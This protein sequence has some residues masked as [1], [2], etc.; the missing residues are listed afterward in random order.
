MKNPIPSELK[1]EQVTAII[2]TREQLPL[3]VSP[4][5]SVAGTLATGDYSVQGLESIV[6]VERKSLSDLLGCIGQHR[7]RFDREVQRLLAYPCRAVVVEAT[8]AEL[9]AG[10]WRSQ[11]TAAAAVGSVLGWI[12]QGVP[13]IMASDH[14]RA[15]RYVSRLLF[16][17]ARRRWREARSLVVSVKPTSQDCAGCDAGGTDGSEHVAGSSP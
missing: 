7:E 5:Q 9:E 11:V 1:P 13:I 15:G 10:E 8:W 16:T 17:A 3:D 6:A 2:D 14:E 4:L 12:A